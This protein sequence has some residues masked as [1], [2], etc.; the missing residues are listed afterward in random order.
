M[1]APEGRVPGGPQALKPLPCVPG[2]GDTLSGQ[3]RHQ[4]VPFTGEEE[5]L[6]GNI[7]LTRAS[8]NLQAPRQSYCSLLG[9]SDF[10]SAWGHAFPLTHERC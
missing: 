7:L 1:W 2:Q 6:R 9:N 4:S 3:N 10:L 5:L 8:L